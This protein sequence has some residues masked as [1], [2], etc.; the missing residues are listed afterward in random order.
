MTASTHSPMLPP[1]RTYAVWLAVIRIYTGVFWLSHGVPKL[2]NPKFV[3]ASGMMAGMLREA[4]GQGH[5]LYNDFLIHV[6]LP[7]AGLFSH[8]VAWGETLTG[9]SLLLG[10]FTRVGGVVG[11]FL[12]L[13]YFMMKGSYG[14]ITAIGSLD[15]A[16][17]ALSFIHVVLPT[18]LVAGLD[19]MLPR[20]RVSRP[21]AGER[22]YK[23]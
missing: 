19:A 18:G 13:N 11:V 12:P 6:V 15:I 10:L 4:T 1:P 2:L 21:V 5:G 7:N 23:G 17:A 22:G 3:G 16:A 20:S 14:D 9:V 8:L